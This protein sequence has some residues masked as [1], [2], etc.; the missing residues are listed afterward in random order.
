MKLQT[1]AINHDAL[2]S[3]REKHQ[4]WMI[5]QNSKFKAKLSNHYVGGE[6]NNPRVMLIGEAPGALEDAKRRPF[7]GDSGLVLREL[8]AL[9]GLFTGSTPHFGTANC[10]LTNVVKFRP[11][12]NRTPTQQEIMSVRQLL[13]ME[14]IAIGQPRIVVPVGGVA[15]QAIYG[16]KLSILGTAAKPRPETSSTRRRM[17]VYPM[18][19][20]SYGLRGGKQVQDKLEEHWEALGAFLETIPKEGDPWRDGTEDVKATVY[21]DNYLDW[22]MGGH[23]AR[24]VGGG[25]LFATDLDALHAFAKSLG[26]KREWYQGKQFPHYDLTK[27]KRDLAIQKG[28]TV[29]EPGTIP[30]GVIRHDPNP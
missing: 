28:A 22:M 15:L 20:P 23:N 16:R 10:W 2:D 7:I 3:I 24:W 1:P 5:Y 11:P 26:L 8:M 14:W 27:G 4:Y 18:I 9:A 30:D 29:V 21:V 12:G 19:H 25:H 13:R 6:G 17:I